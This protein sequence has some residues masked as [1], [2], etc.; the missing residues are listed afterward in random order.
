MIRRKFKGVIGVSMA[1]LMLITSGLTAYASGLGDINDDSVIN[2]LDASEIL[3]EYARVSTNQKAKFND[4][5]KK[6][7]DVDKNC[8]INAVDASHVLS[9]YAYK[10]TSGDMEFSG[11]ASGVRAKTASGDCNLTLKNAPQG[12][13][14]TS[15]SGDLDVCLPSGA[16]C[17]LQLSSRSGDIHFS[18]IRSDIPNAPVYTFTTITGDIDVHS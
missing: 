6:Y 14:M 2:A 16:A 9:Y 8:N 12:M 17:Q 1:G 10:S 7:A 18:G 4:E 3:S 11:L 13:D 5:Q 15:V